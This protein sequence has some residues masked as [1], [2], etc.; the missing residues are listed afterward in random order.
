MMQRKRVLI[1]VVVGTLMV[2]GVALALGLAPSP[3]KTIT[4]GQTENGWE[5]WGT[6]TVTGTA[7]YGHY[8]LVPDNVANFTSFRMV[9]SG[10]SWTDNWGNLIII[11]GTQ[12]GDVGVTVTIIC[13]E[14]DA[15]AILSLYDDQDQDNVPDALEFVQTISVRGW[16]G[17]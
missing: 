1:P 16:D 7:A 9:V 5:G 14:H 12:G 13:D 11:R 4:T 17:N 10:G 3:T 8:I 6:V 2:S 15:S